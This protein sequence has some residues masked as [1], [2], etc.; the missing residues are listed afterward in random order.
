MKRNLSRLALILALAMTL[1]GCSGKA[2]PAGTI[3]PTPAAAPKT[4]AETEAEPE[5]QAETE[6]IP[7]SLGRI[8]GGAYENAYAGYGCTLG[9]DWEYYTAQELQDTTDLTQEM[10]QDAE[11]IEEN[12]EYQTIIAMM[13]E[14]LTDLTSMN[15]N[16]TYLNPQARLGTMLLGEEQ[17]IDSVLDQKDAIAD[18]YTQA[19]I[20]LL[21][22]EKTQVSFLGQERW[23]IR[24]EA[25]I[26]T[27]NGEIPYYTLQLYEVKP[28]G[29]YEV[30]LTLASYMEDNTEALLDLFYLVSE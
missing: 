8:V 5:V 1:S 16:Y 9:D 6:E 7:V 18:A 30:V 3:T 4:Q 21:A 14:N 27:D 20:T 28:G 24:N 11:M 23:A 2:S 10:L 26:T 29:T 12:P 19:N 22:M 15:V 17:L 25:T 13:A